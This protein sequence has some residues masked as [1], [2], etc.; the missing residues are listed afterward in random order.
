MLNVRIIKGGCRGREVEKFGLLWRACSTLVARSRASSTAGTQV[1]T[2]SAK[3]KQDF[4][5]D[6]DQRER[7]D[8]L[9][10]PVCSYNE[11]DPLEE[12]IVG[13]VEGAVKYI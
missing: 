2:C 10:S 9:K 6:L 11:W 3:S 5:D 12:V 13:R 4:P 7:P 1:K 8:E